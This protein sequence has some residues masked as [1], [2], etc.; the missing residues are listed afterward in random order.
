MKRSL[1]FFLLM[2]AATVSG[3]S[4]DP[5]QPESEVAAP[6]TW[7]RLT[8]ASGQSDESV[9]ALSARDKDLFVLT[10]RFFSTVDPEGAIGEKW[11]HHIPA[12][13]ALPFA[14]KDYFVYPINLNGYFAHNSISINW[15]AAAD[16][17]PASVQLPLV[18]LDPALSE[19]ARYAAWDSHTHVAVIN[20]EGLALAP[21]FDSYQNAPSSTY[22]YLIR[23]SPRAPG[24]FSEIFVDVEKRI[25]WPYGPV[26]VIVVGGR[27]FA[28][29]VVAT[30][31]VYDDGA[32]TRLFE[33]GANS[34]IEHDGRLIISNWNGIFASTDGG[35]TWEPVVGTDPGTLFEV[36]GRLCLRRAAGIQVIDLDEGTITTLANNGLPLMSSVFSEAAVQFGD[37]VY[38]GTREGLYS[39]TISDFFNR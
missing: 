25:D 15:S 8:L 29:T 16:G 22:L 1:L 21:V 17:L 11:S 28:S 38:I 39:K 14:S 3:C 32:I 2:L 30:Y 35:E 6:V 12:G 34:M 13:R 4:D 23:L 18:T 37:R 7:Q 10:Q 19:N 9:M 36:D 26:W 33:P 24:D 5:V 20:N 27:F 31:E